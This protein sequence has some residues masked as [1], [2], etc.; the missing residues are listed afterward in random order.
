MK[1]R[2]RKT[3]GMVWFARRLTER[4]DVGLAIV[5]GGH[6]AAGG[7]SENNFDKWKHWISQAIATQMKA[8]QVKYAAISQ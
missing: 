5:G 2:A 8:D 6:A 3:I 7:V 4:S 1:V